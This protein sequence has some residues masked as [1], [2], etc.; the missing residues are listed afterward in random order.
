MW[1]NVWK[2]VDFWIFLMYILVPGK[3]FLGRFAYC[4]VLSS[5]AIRGHFCHNYDS[6]S[7]ILLQIPSEAVY[8][9]SYSHGRT[10][11]GLFAVR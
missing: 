7:L 2:G 9:F 5:G 3:A 10:N 8:V 4:L 11:R 6:S 1:G